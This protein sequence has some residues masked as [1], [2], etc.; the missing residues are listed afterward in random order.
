MGKKKK[1]AKKE[2][3]GNRAAGGVWTS[4]SLTAIPQTSEVAPRELQKSEESASPFDDLLDT[5]KLHWLLGEFSPLETLDLHRVSLHPD[6]A[7][8]A[9]FASLGCANSGK[10]EQAAEALQKAIEW[11][12]SKK[13][14]ARI[15][16]ADAHRSL[17]I[18]FAAKGNETARQLQLEKVNRLLGHTFPADRLLAP[19]KTPPLPSQHPSPS[20]AFSRRRQIL[21]DYDPVL[22]VAGMRHSGSTALFNILRL[23]MEQLGIPY[24]GC[25]SEREDCSTKV[26]GSAFAGIIK[27]HEFRGDILQMADVI[28]T[29]RRDLRDTVASAVRRKFTPFERMVGDKPVEYAKNN[30]ALH[31][32]WHPHSN[33]EF[34]Y[35]RFLADPA[36]VVS[37]VLQTAKVPGQANIPEIVE[38]VRCLPK[39]QYDI[40]LLSPSHITDPEHKLRFSDTLPPDSV[41]KISLQHFDWLEKFGY[42]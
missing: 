27:T 13:V 19:P 38:K 37:E 5:V 31:D 8:L 14:A 21:A 7:L 29:T 2:R 23:A 32:L 17:G 1:S 40:T 28:F 22:V 4:D 30:R 24:T 34:V 39:D 20:A 10:N 16:L 36:A 41:A 18:C 35:E 11:G 42:E 33:Y 26:L 6:R 9:L 3:A 15:L 25:Y 12:C